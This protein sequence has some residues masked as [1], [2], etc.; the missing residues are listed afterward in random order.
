LTT[1]SGFKAGES[2][3]R[4]KQIYASEDVQF[5]TDTALG[6]IFELRG[7]DTSSLLL[8]GPVQGTDDSSLVMGIYAPDVCGR[9]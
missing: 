7:S 4:L 5:S 6:E 3:E 9:S 1:L 2:V 8:W